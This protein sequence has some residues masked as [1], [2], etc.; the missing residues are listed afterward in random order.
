MARARVDQRRDDR[1]G[2]GACEPA[3]LELEL[4]GV[5]GRAALG[6]RADPPRVVDDLVRPADEAVQGVDRGPDREGQAARR[7]VEG[8][9]VAALQAPAGAVGLL[10]AMRS[11][12]HDREG[13]SPGGRR[14]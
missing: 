1:V 14:S 6:G 8:R 5:E 4:P 12:F 13:Y 11:P 7:G 10:Q 9:V 2:G 3:E